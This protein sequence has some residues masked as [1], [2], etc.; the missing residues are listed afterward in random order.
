MAV[1]ALFTRG[2]SVKKKALF[3]INIVEAG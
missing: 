1:K 3:V 2:K